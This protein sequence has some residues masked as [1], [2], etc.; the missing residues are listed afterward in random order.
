MRILSK[1]NLA[2]HGHGAPRLWGNVASP[3]ISRLISYILVI[4]Y[5][6]TGEGN[7]RRLVWGNSSTSTNSESVDAFRRATTWH[8]RR[9]GHQRSRNNLDVSNPVRGHAG[10]QDGAGH[11]ERTSARSASL[12]SSTSNR[13]DKDQ[14][15]KRRRAIVP[16]SPPP[17]ENEL[18]SRTEREAD[19]PASVQRATAVIAKH[20][21]TKSAKLLFEYETGIAGKCKVMYLD[22]N[23]LVQVCLRACL[24]RRISPLLSICLCDRTC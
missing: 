18:I 8:E 10:V 6:N 13:S 23:V 11:F 5:R 7:P 9:A 12:M 4:L 15:S 22:K 2:G 14:A 1:S 21:V 16:S 19:V 24:L 20:D 3:Q 17:D